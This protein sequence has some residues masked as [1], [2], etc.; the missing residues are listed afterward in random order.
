MNGPVPGGRFAGYEVLTLL[1]KGGMG[2]VYGVR[3][4]DLDR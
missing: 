2:S 4:T 3:N 1:G